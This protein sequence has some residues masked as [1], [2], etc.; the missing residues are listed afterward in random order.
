MRDDMCINRGYR[1]YHYVWVVLFGAGPVASN[2]TFS[3]EHFVEVAIVLC[4]AFRWVVLV[5]V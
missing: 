1:W 2:K 4:Q 3:V 5:S